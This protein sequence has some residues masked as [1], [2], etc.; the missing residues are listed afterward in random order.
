MRCAATGESMPPDKRQVT[1]PLMLTGKPPGPRIFPAETNAARGRISIA[2]ATAGS[3]RSTRA[4]VASRTASPTRAF[5]CGDV[6]GNDLSARRVTIANDSIGARDAAATAASE[7][8]S[9]SSAV[10]TPHEKFAT[11]KVVATRA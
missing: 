10:A 8:A 5:T 6:S 2:I 3:S 9:R 4:P 1:R 11:P 7:I